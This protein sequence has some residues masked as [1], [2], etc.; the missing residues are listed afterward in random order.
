LKFG[1]L[2][3]GKIPLSGLSI[4]AIGILET[5]E[6]HRVLCAMLGHGL[7]AVEEFSFGRWV[8]RHLGE[9][10]KPNSACTIISGISL[11]MLK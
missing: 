7:T 2:E 1:V 10:G 11:S 9:P 4:R 3:Q 6:C 5:S 8:L